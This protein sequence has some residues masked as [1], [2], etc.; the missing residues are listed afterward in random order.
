M[1]MKLSK[2]HK[3]TEDRRGSEYHKVNRSSA[4]AGGL[5][6]VSFLEDKGAI[7]AKQQAAETKTVG[8]QF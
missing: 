4:P 6:H 3:A 2:T 1:A 8:V 5:R 7:T